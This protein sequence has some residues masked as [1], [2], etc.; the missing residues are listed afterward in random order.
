MELIIEKKDLLHFC[1]RQCFGQILLCDIEKLTDLFV[2]LKFSD[3][4]R[5]ETENVI[6]GARDSRIRVSGSGSRIAGTGESIHGSAALSMTGISK[7]F[8]QSD[9]GKLL[10][11]SI[12]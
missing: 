7:R 3:P 12:G 2:L 4:V 11:C 1:R 8:Q 10:I 9:P 6:S 5:S